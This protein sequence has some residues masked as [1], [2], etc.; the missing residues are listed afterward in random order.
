MNGVK[1]FPLPIWDRII[2]TYFSDGTKW[3]LPH[4]AVYTTKTNLGIGTE[5]V[6]NFSEIDTFYDKKTKTWNMD[7]EYN[8][9]AKVIDD[10]MVQLA[11]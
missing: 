8:I 7:S 4:R 6:A 5:E 9:D 11:Y 1:V 2:R 3:E 10:S